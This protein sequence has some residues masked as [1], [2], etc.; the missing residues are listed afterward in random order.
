MG[1]GENRNILYN[2]PLPLH[3]SHWKEKQW[4]ILQHETESEVSQLFGIFYKEQNNIF[5]ENT[6]TWEHARCFYWHAFN[7]KEILLFKKKIILDCFQTMQ[8]ILLKSTKIRFKI[9][10]TYLVLIF[11][12]TFEY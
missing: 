7:E 2:F 11:E 12:N 5:Y 9:Q 3:L 8:L 1:G 6:G 4:K 10:K